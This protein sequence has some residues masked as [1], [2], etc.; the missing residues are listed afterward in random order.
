MTKRGIPTETEKTDKAK[1]SAIRC[2]MA[3]PSATSRNMN[4]SKRLHTGRNTPNTMQLSGRRIISPIQETQTRVKYTD[5]GSDL[6]KTIQKGDVP[7]KNS[8]L[9]KF[10]RQNS[11]NRLYATNP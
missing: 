7:N 4:N 8:F 11:A 5:F 10:V 9:H 6:S 1:M 2:N 3:S